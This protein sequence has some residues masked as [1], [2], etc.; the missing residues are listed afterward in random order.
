M[1]TIFIIIIA[2]VLSTTA[3]AKNLVI[4]TDKDVYYYQDVDKDHVIIL[5]NDELVEAKDIIDV[6]ENDRPHIT[7]EGIEIYKMEDERYYIDGEFESE[8]NDE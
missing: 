7:R 6:E 3:Y 8:A 4:Y 2:I 5:P 1:K